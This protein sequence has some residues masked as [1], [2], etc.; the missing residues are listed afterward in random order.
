MTLHK[1]GE[2]SRAICPF[3]KQ[4][5]TTT[6]REREVPLSSGKG[7]VKDLLL[8]VCDTCDHV[9][10]IPQQSVPRVKE[11]VRSSRHALETRVPRHL[12]DAVGLVCVALGQGPEAAAVLFRFYLERVSSTKRSRARLA[13]LC[14][15]EEAQ[16]R[17]GARFSAKLSDELYERLKLLERS[18]SLNQAEVVKGLMVQMKRD[19]LDRGRQDRGRQDLRRDLTALLRV[20]G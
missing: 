18:T 1:L 6:F 7:V 19:I 20:A 16:G 9:V 14:T 11:A 8:A 17:A 15:S 5:R 13:A 4:L 2:K 10:S 3:C 12:L